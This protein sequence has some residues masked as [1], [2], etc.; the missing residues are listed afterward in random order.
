MVGEQGP[1]PFWRIG[2]LITRG[3][4]GSR[5]TL[6][7]EGS[8]EHRSLESLTPSS[9]AKLEKNL[10]CYAP[11]AGHIY[12]TNRDLGEKK[13]LPRKPKEGIVNTPGQSHMS[14]ASERR[15]L[16]PGKVVRYCHSLA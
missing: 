13:E 14:I 15:Y 11:N 4:E 2:A 9:P 12:S 1:I 10:I 3:F 7:L 5:F 8:E 6:L 16:D